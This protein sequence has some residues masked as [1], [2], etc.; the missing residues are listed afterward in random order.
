[1]FGIN[2]YKYETNTFIS[3]MRVVKDTFER[4]MEKR[5]KMNIEKIIQ[6][7]S[8]G[9]I[10]LEYTSLNS[11]VTKIREVTTCWEYMP[12]EAKV[13]ALSLIHI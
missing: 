6:K 5:K 13:F 4:R 10:L 3:F 8:E 1:M 7:M 11:G 12:D 9:I 2:L